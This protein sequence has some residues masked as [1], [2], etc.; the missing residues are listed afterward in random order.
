MWRI[1]SPQEISQESSPRYARSRRKWL[2][3]GS[4]RGRPIT[5]AH[6][7]ISCRLYKIAAHQTSS[8]IEIVAQ[9]KL[10]P[11]QKLSPVR[12]GSWFFAKMF[13]KIILRSPTTRRLYGYVC[14]VHNV[15]TRLSGDS[16]IQSPV[17][18]LIQSL[19][20]L[21]SNNSIKTR[22][23]FLQEYIGISDLR[24]T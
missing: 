22:T 11:I 3:G 17:V 7:K 6:N 19:H 10:W 21:K 9:Q 23:L 8:L 14:C 13:S 18:L 1:Y 20:S 24:S 5:V 16:R 4:S 2:R 12:S 15:F